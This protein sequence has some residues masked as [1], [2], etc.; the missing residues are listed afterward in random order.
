MEHYDEGEIVNVGVGQD[1][2]IKDLAELI[3]DV[4]GYSGEL[5]FDP[6]RPDGTPRKRHRRQT[7]EPPVTA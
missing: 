2:S 5:V 3:A 6:A 1:I 4:V 7:S